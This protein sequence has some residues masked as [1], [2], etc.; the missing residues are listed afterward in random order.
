MNTVYTRFKSIC[1]GDIKDI[2]ST[3]GKVS[4]KDYQ[5]TVAK[6]KN[7]HQ[8]TTLR[9]AITQQATLMYTTDQLISRASSQH[10]ESILNILILLV[11]YS[12]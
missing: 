8:L 7:N 4:T 12:K 6:F 5:E 11:K 9:L 10:N 1:K 3:V 2:P